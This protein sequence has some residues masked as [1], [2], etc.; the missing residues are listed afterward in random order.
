[1]GFNTALNYDK[2][3]EKLGAN[4]SIPY[5]NMRYYGGVAQVDCGVFLANTSIVFL[6]VPGGRRGHVII[7]Y[8]CHLPTR[9]AQ[10]EGTTFG[11][12]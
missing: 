1:L 6:Q 4:D 10:N 11:C 12:V 5:Y 7:S 3:F 9:A 8:L 2:Y